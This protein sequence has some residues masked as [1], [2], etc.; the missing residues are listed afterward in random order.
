MIDSELSI[1]FKGEPLNEPEKFIT[2]NF[3]VKALMEYFVFD[4]DDILK[5]FETNQEQAISDYINKLIGVE[6]LDNVIYSLEVVE[7]L[8]ENEIY[9]IESQIQDD[10]AEKIKQ[11]WED[12]KRKEEAIKTYD[13][14]INGLKKKKKKIF[15]KSPSPEEKKLYTLISKRDG[16]KEKINEINQNFIESKMTSNIDLLLI[17]P[18]IFSMEKKMEKAKTSKEDF[19]ASAKLVQS[20][21]RPDFKG[22][23]FDEEKN[24]KIIKSSAKINSQDLDDVDKLGLEIT[25][26]VKTDVMKVICKYKELINSHKDGFKQFC[27]ECKEIKSLF[28]KIQ[29]QIDQIGETE[30]TKQTKEKYEQFKEI[31]KT[32][33]TKEIEKRGTLE[34]KQE[35]EKRIGEYREKLEFDEKQKKEKEKLEKKKEYVKDLLEVSKETREKFLSKLI[36]FINE[37]ASESLRNTVKDINRFHSI[38]IN[39]NYE[40]K[41]KQ[42]NGE[43]L[44]QSQINKGTLTISMLSFFFGLS[45]FLEKEIPYVIDNPMIRLDPGHDKRLIE[46]LIKKSDQVI[47]HIIPGKEYTTDSFSWLKPNINVQNW[48]YRNEYQQRDDLISTTERQDESQ[49]IKFD[50]DTF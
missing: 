28:F 46:Q 14:E 42:K 34:K 12:K 18:I 26:G 45:S 22:V 49:I 20:S 30:G 43:I 40:F 5:K 15:E 29:N 33:E 9:Q 38:E 44:K 24:T 6:K 35:I 16:L 25:G 27:K 21:L 10:L 4:A 41:V 37:R 3:P 23:F 7:K 17:E 31:E 8:Y 50:I 32:V 1:I 2:D 47:L 19:D 48:I 36:N 39:T 11:E 13:N